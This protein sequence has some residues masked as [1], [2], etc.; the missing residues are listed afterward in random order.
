MVPYILY[1][2][3]RDLHMMLYFFK[4]FTKVKMIYVNYVIATTEGTVLDTNFV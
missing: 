1:N 2:K 3:K 4:I